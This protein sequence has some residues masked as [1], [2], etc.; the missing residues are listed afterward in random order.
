MSEKGSGLNRGQEDQEPIRVSDYLRLRR[1]RWGNHAA[2]R[3]G[4]DTWGISDGP[5]C[6]P[7]PASA[8]G[9]GGFW[10]RPLQWYR[11]AVARG[12]I[13]PLLEPLTR[14]LRDGSVRRFLFV[15]AVAFWLGGFT[16]YA[17]VV[18]HVGSRVLG[19]ELQQGL[20]TRE[21]SRWINVA[22]AVALPLLLWNLLATWRDR[23]RLGRV[24]LASTWAAMAAI[25]V[26]LFALHP[27]L[28]RLLAT[29]AWRNDPNGRFESLHF[30]YLMSSTAQWAAGVLHVWCVTAGTRQ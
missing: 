27:M 24:V 3:S 5:F 19:S 8:P 22:A 6:F 29:P 25:Q 20:V 28:D 9:R 18:I 2:V 11:P 21:V 4:A 14:P 10:A 12:A 30:L 7:H 17:G 15:A 13:H 1:G 16:F 26:E 23:G